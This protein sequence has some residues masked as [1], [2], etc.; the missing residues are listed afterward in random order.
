MFDSLKGGLLINLGD[1]DWVMGV[2]SM[3]LCHLFK[4]FRLACSVVDYHSKITSHCNVACSKCFSL[5][6]H[7]FNSFKVSYSWY[8]NVFFNKL[9]V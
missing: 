1:G 2:Q 5:V 3:K 6:T 9:G 4:T 8:F 7:V